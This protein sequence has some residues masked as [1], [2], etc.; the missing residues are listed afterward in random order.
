M[1]PIRHHFSSTALL[2]VA[3]PG[4]VAMTPCR[5][6]GQVVSKQAEQSP[7]R[8]WPSD[9]PESCPFPKST[10][11]TGIALTGRHKEYGE[12][13]K[14]PAGADTWFPSWASDGNLYSPYADGWVGNVRVGGGGPNSTE[15]AAE[16]IGDDP[17]N[18]KLVPLTP[19]PV[20]SVPYG[21]RY[22]RASLVYNGTWYYGT[23]VLDV[24][25]SKEY[26]CWWCVVGPFVG[27]GI[28]AT[29]GSPG[30]TPN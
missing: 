22:P 24:L 21:G 6:A 4:L 5:G 28:R 12:P 3:I 30:R 23:Y 7:F 29:M 13:G 14:V 9:P 8:V 25:E 2:L 26:N 15:G 16:I 17:M 20:S 18:L 27:F 1:R 19:Y 10:V 11:I